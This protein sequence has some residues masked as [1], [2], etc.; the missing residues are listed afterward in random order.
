MSGHKLPAWRYWSSQRWLIGWNVHE[1]ALPLLF[2]WNKYS[3]SLVI[4][5]FEVGYRRKQK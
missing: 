3:I 4:F 5:I 1:I 2:H